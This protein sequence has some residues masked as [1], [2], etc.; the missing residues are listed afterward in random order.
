MQYRYAAQEQTIFAGFPDWSAALGPCLRP[1]DDELL[2]LSL[3]FTDIWQL[4]R[5]DLTTEEDSL[6]VEEVVT[7]CDPGLSS[8]F[9]G[10]D[11]VLYNGALNELII[12]GDR[13]YSLDLETSACARLPLKQ[14][15]LQI[16]FAAENEM[17]AVVFGALMQMDR[18]TGELVIIS[19]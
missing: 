19:K 3:P 5:F 15:P 8:T 9:Q 14:F 1:F 13:L 12:G 10:L 17:L 4:R 18:E 7:S 11:Q 6:I 2:Y 16:Q